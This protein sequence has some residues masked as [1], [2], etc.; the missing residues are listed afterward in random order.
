MAGC[1]IIPGD[2]R[3]QNRNGKLF[4]EF[5]ERNPHLSVVN[6]LP[7]CEGLITRSRFRDEKWEKSVLDF[8]VICDRVLPYLTKIV[9]DERKQHSLT[10]YQ[11]VK[12]GGKVV[13]TDHCT[14]YMDLDLEVVSCK[15]ERREIF[16]FKETEGQKRFKE[17]TSKTNEFSA[18]F[19]NNLPLQ[20]QIIRWQATLKSYCKKA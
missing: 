5:L 10:N 7:Q 14:E 4:K 11:N 15:P 16:N 20:Q 17:L 13:D 19:E 12:N 8:F 18:C 6:A 9:S 1:D 2:P 3:H